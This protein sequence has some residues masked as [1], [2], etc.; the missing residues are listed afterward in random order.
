M[1]KYWMP[2][3]LY[4]GGAEH[5]VLHLL[6]AR[7]WHKVLYDI[8]VV[9][10]REPFRRLFNQ[11]MILGELEYTLYTD[12]RG[13]PVGPEQVDRDGKHKVTEEELN[14]KTLKEKDVVKQGDQFV[15]KSDREVPVVARSAKMSKSRGNVVNP[16]DIIDQYGADSLRLYEMFMGPLEQVKPWNTKGVEGVYRFLNRAWRLILDE[17]GQPLPSVVDVEP[18]DDQNRLLHATIQKVT[19]DIEALRFNTAIA[20]MMEFVNAARKWT[21]MP[22]R[23]MESF[24]LI[25]G[26][27]AP[28]IAEEMWQKLGHDNTFGYEPWPAVNE[29]VL[30]EDTIELAVQVMGKVRGTISVP[31]DSDRD[32]VLAA[33]RS[34]ENVARHLSGKTIR[35]EIYVPG[36]IVNFVAT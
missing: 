28:H 21:M 34:E 9:S 3:D 15:L 27:F 36:R 6:Y 5:A 18:G 23:V 35:K 8:G 20:T 22:K 10:T 32:T 11:G 12:A 4:I 14:A 19:E 13:H 30:K 31:V 33:A 7:F 17:E 29:A 24:V 25:L 26:P 16:D 2:V 1:E